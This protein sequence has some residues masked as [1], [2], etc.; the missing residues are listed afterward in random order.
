MATRQVG[1]EGGLVCFPSP[2][3]LVF[4]M[5]VS[6]LMDPFTDFFAWGQ[7]ISHLLSSPNLYSQFRGLVC[8]VC[9]AQS[10]TQILSSCLAWSDVWGLGSTD[11]D[12]DPS[13]T[14][15]SPGALGYWGRTRMLYLYR[16][17][18]LSVVMETNGQFRHAHTHL[19]VGCPALRKWAGWLGRWLGGCPVNDVVTLFFKCCF[20]FCYK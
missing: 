13:P 8:Q 9:V 19:P 1:K 4:L 12:S 3:F 17:C 11:P 7:V 5:W 14:E 18:P 6:T 15:S 10:W 2:A 20:Q 16:S